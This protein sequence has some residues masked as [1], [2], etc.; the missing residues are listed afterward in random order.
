M[1]TPKLTILNHPLLNVKMTIL[2]DEKTR[3]QE[4]RKTLREIAYLM[5]FE[6]FK[7][8]KI[9]KISVTTPLETT[10][11][12]TL[13][14]YSPCLISILR[15]GN[16]LSEALLDIMPEA[17]MGHLGMERDHNTQLPH[18]YYQKLPHNIAERQVIMVDPMLATGGTATMAASHLKEHNVKDIIFATL[19][20]APEGIEAFSKQHPD[21]Q[22][23][24]VA[25]DRCLNQNG[26]ILPGL[27]DAGDRIYNTPS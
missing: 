16:G 7:H 21:I 3:P 24:T 19:L 23:I 12:F 17:A 15:A 13:D 8:I 4:F 22:I 2:R 5:S 9:R 26:Y 10:D 1:N 6:V 25:Q 20:A 11:G 18:A 14:S 27:G